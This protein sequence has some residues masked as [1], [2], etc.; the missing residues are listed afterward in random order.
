[1]SEL[2]ISCCLCSVTIA[3]AVDE[4]V[5]AVD[6]DDARGAGDSAVEWP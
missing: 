6:N 5:V 1:M 4:P 2:L 3:M